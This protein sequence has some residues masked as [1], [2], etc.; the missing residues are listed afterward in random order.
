MSNGKSIVYLK[1]EEGS[2]LS[3]NVISFLQLSYPKTLYRFHIKETWILYRGNDEDVSKVVSD[4]YQQYEDME[5]GTK[6]SKINDS[7][8]HIKLISFAGK[9]VQLLYLW[10]Q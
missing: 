7:N 9:K 10:F 4:A 2:Q 3:C 1:H 6:T 5:F 8:R